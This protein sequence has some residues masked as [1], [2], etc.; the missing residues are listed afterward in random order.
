MIVVKY[1]VLYLLI[2]A[3]TVLVAGFLIRSGTLYRIE[4][5]RA[6]Q[7]VFATY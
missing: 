3:Y 5:E 7:R 4:H 2:V 6:T 1:V